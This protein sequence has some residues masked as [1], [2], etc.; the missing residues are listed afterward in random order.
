MKKIHL[1]V[2]A[3]NEEAII[4][5]F[6][7]SFAPHVDAITLVRAIGTQEAD[8][9]AE[10]AAIRGCHLEEYHNAPGHHWP[11]VDDFAAARNLAFR[12]PASAGC[13]YLMWA[14]IDDL[15]SEEGQLT[16]AEIRA[17]SAPEFGAATAPYIVGADG[18]ACQRIRLVSASAFV[19][20][21]NKVHEDIV[22]PAGTKQIH[23][24]GLKV[25]HAPAT[26]KRTSQERNRRILDAIPADQ[27]TG[28]EWWFLSRECELQNDIPA[29]L[30]AAVIASG[31]DDLGDQEKFSAYLSIGRWIKDPAEAARPLLECVRLDPFRR[32]PFGEL[33]QIHLDRGEPNLASDY[34]ALMQS[35]PAPAEPPWNHDASLHSW[36]G[37]D[38][39]TR[40]L[41]QNG[42]AE[43][44]AKRRRAWHKHH[45][46]R[47]SVA[48]PTCRPEKAIKIRELWLG[49]ANHPENIEY[50]FGIE[51]EA[52]SHRIAEFP[53]ALSEP[54]PDGHSSAVANYNAAAAATSG[55]IIIAAQD[56]IYPPHG[57]DTQ[58]FEAL[59]RHTA[60]PRVL[61]LHDGFRT[62]SIMVI[63]CVTR[64]WLKK[65]GT[66][67]SPE[68]DGYYSDTEFSYRAYEAGE[69]I[70]GRH[71]KFYHDHPA[72]TGAE[73]DESYM[74]Q[75][76]PE[77]FARG[78]ATFERRNPNA[79]VW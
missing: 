44:A 26:L 54:V 17:G 69:V 38:I 6:L 20:W 58:V 55:P 77:A 62:D 14:D 28:R 46:I 37:L 64:A 65:H 4:A 40:A 11:H 78:K 12:S 1:G 30:H 49:R 21:E 31:R 2:I 29:A 15:L 70:H 5:R 10:I 42:K 63:M 66:L 48:H 50:I 45:G 72:F 60:Q 76:N 73:S 16:L 52:A 8:R 19:G 61:H 67:L 56:D 24:P 34:A 23:C 7:D 68:Y 74:R 53:H 22:L 3:G 13:D 79:G 59:V 33:A 51:P 32:E 41:I 18:S 47:I 39:T 35:I 36:R 9:T 27:R 25:I 71:I 43:E 75:Q 57:W